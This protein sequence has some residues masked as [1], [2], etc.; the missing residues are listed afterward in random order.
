[1]RWHGITGDAR[2]ARFYGVV[3]SNNEPFLFV[4]YTIRS[5]QTELNVYKINI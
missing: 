1:M 2:S 4:V 3:A 5:Q